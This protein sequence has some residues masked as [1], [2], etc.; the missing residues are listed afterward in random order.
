MDSTTVPKPYNVSDE[1]P[2]FPDS[3]MDFLAD[4][5]GCSDYPRLRARVIDLWREV[6]AKVRRP[7]WFRVLIGVGAPVP[8]GGNAP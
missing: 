4:C 3:H 1:P 5:T 2:D 8:F 6:K 7:R